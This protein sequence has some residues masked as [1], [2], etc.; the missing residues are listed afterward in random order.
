MVSGTSGAGAR[1]SHVPDPEGQ[2][3][4]SAEVLTWRKGGVVRGTVAL[5]GRGLGVA[6]GAWLR[7]G[8]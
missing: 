7:A 2:G 5:E 8:T 4:G 3:T 6:E 1:P